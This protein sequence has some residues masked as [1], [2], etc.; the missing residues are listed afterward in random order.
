V[1]N[2]KL[3][4]N[5]L[6]LLLLFNGVFMTFCLPTSVYHGDGDAVPLLLSA[7]ICINIGALLWYF[8]RS[9]DKKLKNKDG[10]LIVT[11][12]WLT[13]SLTGCLPY[14][15]SGAIPSFTSAFFETV[16]GYTTTGSTVLNDIE[17]VHKGILLWRSLTQWMGGMGIIVLAVAIL[18]IL[19]VGGMQLFIA[20]SPR[21][22]SK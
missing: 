16:S 14:L 20:E 4:G 8:T 9:Y 18:P 5:I 12:G 3:I 6:G 13:L 2:F 19:G 11:F 7:A 22:I 10:Y 15:L 17:S 1:F 21:A